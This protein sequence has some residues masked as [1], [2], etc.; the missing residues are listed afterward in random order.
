MQLGFIGLTTQVAKE[1]RLT[2]LVQRLMLSRI[3]R[4][5][6]SGA[7][8]KVCTHCIRGFA[9]MRYINL[10]LTLKT[11]GLWPILAMLTARSNVS[12]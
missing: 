10:R 9:T 1:K 2:L 6:F 12:L 11:F 5:A 4:R 7:G 8:L 3:S